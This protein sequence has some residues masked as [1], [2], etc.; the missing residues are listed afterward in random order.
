MI[1]PPSGGKIPKV[2]DAPVKSK[3]TSHRKVVTYGNF[4]LDMLN[5]Y[6]HTIRLNP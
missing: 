1:L 6:E 5:H 4:R 3:N 2:V